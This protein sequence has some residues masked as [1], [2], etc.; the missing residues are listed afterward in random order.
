[1]ILK[2]LIGIT[3]SA[4]LPFAFACFAA[5]KAYFRAAFVIILLIFFYP[6]TFSKI[7]LFTPLWLLAMLAFSKLVEAR[8]AVVLS[9]TAPVALGI[10]LIILFRAD[11]RLYFSIVNVRM[12]AIPSVAMDVYNDFFS[13][14]ELTSFC[15][16]SFLKPIMQC[17]YQEPLSVVMEGAY[18]IGNFNASL[19]AT[20]GIASVG[21]LL[22]PLTAL[23]SGLLI[24]C[25][26]R[27]SSGL[28]SSFVLVS[29]AV[30]PQVILNVPLTTVMLTHGL[31]FLFLLWYVTPRTIFDPESVARQSIEH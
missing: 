27:F 24:S 14:H 3:S 29:G 20:E 15:Q 18:K 8:L 22:A 4:L 16:I 13:R 28:P 31:A 5:R 26:N 10:L 1:M 25:G 9:L 19:F 23:A 6:I 17:P 7:A 21:V 2:Y 11:A 12:V 30:I